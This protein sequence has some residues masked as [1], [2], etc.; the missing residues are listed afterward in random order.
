MTFRSK[1]YGLGV[2]VMV[3]VPLKVCAVPLALDVNGD[4]A[5]VTDSERGVYHFSAADLKKLPEYTIETST[6]WTRREKWQGPR[7]SDVLAVVGARGRSIRVYAYDDFRQDIP[8][9]MIEK[10]QPVL[11]YKENGVNLRLDN[12]GPLFIVFPRDQ[13]PELSQIVNMRRFVFQIR[14]IEVQR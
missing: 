10:Y 11:A 6:N 4:I 8:L 12:F 13:H 1:L 9:S 7:L 5:N 2:L 3:A 14:R